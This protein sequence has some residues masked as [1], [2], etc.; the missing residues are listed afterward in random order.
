MPFST[1]PVWAVTGPVALLSPFGSGERAAVLA[2]QRGDVAAVGPGLVDARP[3]LID[4]TR[5]GVLL[6]GQLRHPPGVDDV[7]RG[8]QEAHLLAGRDDDRVVHFQQVV[9]AHVRARDPGPVLAA[10]GARRGHVAEE[11]DVLVH[12]LRRPL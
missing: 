1:L 11:A 9:L 10:L 6:D 8:H 4:E 7:V 12:V 2:A 5:Y 3:G